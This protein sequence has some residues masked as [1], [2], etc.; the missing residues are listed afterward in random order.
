MRITNVVISFPYRARSLGTAMTTGGA[1]RRKDWVK[2]S[3][4]GQV[5]LFGENNERGKRPS[6]SLR[7]PGERTRFS[8]PL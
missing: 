4:I 1:E 7:N 8:S 6:A 3:E 5:E 2:E